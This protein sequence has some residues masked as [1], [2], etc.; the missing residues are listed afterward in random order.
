[1]TPGNGRPPVDNADKTLGDIVAQVSEQASTLV[2]SEIELAKAEVTD[3]VSKL[4]KGAG[5]AAAA[6]VF[7]VFAV[8]MFF[9][10]L[11]WLFDD[12]FGW[13]GSVWPG[14]LIVTVLLLIAAAIAGFIAYRLFQKGAPPTP[15]LAIEEARL[16]RAQ[17]EE[18]TVQRDQ[19]ARSLDKG[20]EARN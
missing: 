11:A 10:F 14:F 1:M 3:K 2:R 15:D 7:L 5:I 9:Q 4:G 8:T 17:L 16:M 12:L 19:L 20:Q 18:Q 6:G 13:T